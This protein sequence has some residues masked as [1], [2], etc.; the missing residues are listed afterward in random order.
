MI[1]KMDP[2]TP[3]LT[4]GTTSPASVVPAA[5][6]AH[7]QRNQSLV[8]LRSL[9]TLS[10]CSAASESSCAPLARCPHCL[11]AIK[12][13]DIEKISPDNQNKTDD[14]ERSPM[15][16][17]ERSSPGD[18]TRVDP[19]TKALLKTI[20][21]TDRDLKRV[22][23]DLHQIHLLNPTPASSRTPSAQSLVALAQEQ[24]KRPAP[25]GNPSSHSENGAMPP[26]HRNEIPSPPGPASGP[27][28]SPEPQFKSAGVG[29]QS[30]H[31]LIR[32]FGDLVN[33]SQANIR[34]LKTLQDRVNKVDAVEKLLK[35]ER[36][37]LDRE[38][39]NI[40]QMRAETDKERLRLMDRGL[41]WRSYGA[42]SPVAMS[43]GD[44]AGTAVD[45]WLKGEDGDAA[46]YEEWSEEKE[47]QMLM[48]EERLRKAQMGWSDEQ[49]EILGP[50]EKLREEKRQGAKARRLERQTSI[51]FDRIWSSD[52]KTEKGSSHKK[53]V[54]RSGSPTGSATRHSKN[55]ITNLVRRGSVG[56]A[57]SRRVGSVHT[58]QACGYHG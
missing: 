50:L 43:R 52:D 11:E 28:S 53:S 16:T 7:F 26:S 58:V 48:L 49:E 40:M 31:P 54:D 12:L 14:A 24:A 51:K 30:G 13:T 35:A 34:L 1:M 3:A 36:E 4:P 37:A 10:V 32:D 45:E 15:D 25:P 38:R 22:C 5:N 42:Q 6:Q 2:P 39:E 8:S 9:L 21:E 55:R 57:I 29:F 33:L 41:C 17:S 56:S 44:S 27:S 20:Q 19:A 46:V 18:G 23:Q 47:Q